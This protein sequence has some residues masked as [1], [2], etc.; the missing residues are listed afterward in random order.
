MGLV[1]LAFNVHV[2]VY[3][4]IVLVLPF[5]LWWCCE[6]HSFVE[7]LQDGAPWKLEYHSSIEA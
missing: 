4:L 7:A 2:C 1:Q 5:D 3:Y 6:L